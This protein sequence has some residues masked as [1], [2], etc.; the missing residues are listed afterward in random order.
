MGDTDI[1][2]DI[3]GLAFSA[4]LNLAAGKRAFNRILEGNRLFNDLVASA[5]TP[6]GPSKIVERIRE[7]ASQPID[8]RYE[9]PSD[10]AFSAYLKALAEA[11]DPKTVAEAA[12]VVATV[13][14]CGW[15]ADIARELLSSALASGLAFPPTGIAGNSGVPLRLLSFNV[16][17]DQLVTSLQEQKSPE[18][19]WGVLAQLARSSPSGE[20][21]NLDIR[22][23]F[24]PVA[25]RKRSRMRGHRSPSM[26]KRP[27]SLRTGRKYASVS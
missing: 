25:V 24:E 23:Q 1:L 12:K 18:V 11:C 6:T 10:V 15:A 8:E 13:P 27:S 4:E 5:R 20:I 16:S 2:N 21:R 19:S 22:G 3:E 17:G 7:L 26:Q 14:G 9:H